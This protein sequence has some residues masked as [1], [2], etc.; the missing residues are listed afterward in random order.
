MPTRNPFEITPEERLRYQAVARLAN[1]LSE[2]AWAAQPD[3]TLSYYNRHWF[4][5]TGLTLQ[6]AKGA[7]WVGVVHPADLPHVVEQWTRAL[8]TGESFE[9]EYRLLRSD[10]SYRW[11][12]GR[13]APVRNAAGQIVNWFGTSSDIEDHKREQKRVED[14]HARG[15]NNLRDLVRMLGNLGYPNAEIRLANADQGNYKLAG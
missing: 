12:V 10:G 11:H 13:G 8:A 5:Y 3:G 6:Q 15:Q 7:G 2:I 1:G 14:S 9:F 4:S